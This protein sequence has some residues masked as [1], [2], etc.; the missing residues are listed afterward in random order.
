[1]NTPKEERSERFYE[2]QFCD[3]TNW[4]PG[5]FE[6]YCETVG[7][8]PN[9]EDFFAHQA[10]ACWEQLSEEAKAAFAFDFDCWL[11]A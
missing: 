3:A 9:P 8:E 5:V 7:F 6:Q 1:M 10:A 11:D 2:A 4:G